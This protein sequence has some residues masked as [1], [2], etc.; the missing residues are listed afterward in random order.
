MKIYFLNI[1]VTNK[2]NRSLIR[3]KKHELTFKIQKTT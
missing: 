1:N 2:T 3:K